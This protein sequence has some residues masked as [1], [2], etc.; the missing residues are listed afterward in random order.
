MTFLTS[1]KHNNKALRKLGSDSL[2]NLGSNLPTKCSC[3]SLYPHTWDHAYHPELWH[4]VYEHFSNTAW[5]H[6]TEELSSFSLVGLYIWVSF[7]FFLS[8][9]FYALITYKMSEQ[10]LHHFLVFLLSPSL[11]FVTEGK[12]AV[13]RSLNSS[14]T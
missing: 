3:I 5:N 1:R 13:R 9:N 4:S 2:M 6:H 8:G 10:M 11:F 14:I 12:P 7:F